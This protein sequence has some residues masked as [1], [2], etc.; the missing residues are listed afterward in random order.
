MTCDTCVCDTTNRHLVKNLVLQ[1]VGSHY[2]LWG[3][4][5]VKFERDTPQVWGTEV[6]WS[7]V[8]RP[9]LWHIQGR[10]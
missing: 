6:V 3:G 9:L 1:Y 10:V 7:C 8:L 5:S 4:Q 2:L